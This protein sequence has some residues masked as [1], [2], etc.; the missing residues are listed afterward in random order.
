MMQKRFT[1]TQ[2]LVGRENPRRGAKCSPGHLSAESA[3]SVSQPIHSNFV[4]EEQYMKHRGT[5]LSLS[6][7]AL[8]FALATARAQTYNPVYTYPIGSGAYSGIT[9][10]SLLS[11]GQ[12][13]ALYSTIQN[14][15]DTYGSVYEITTEGQYTMLY[16][17]CAEGSPCA[18]TGGYPTGGVTLG[19]DGNLWGTTK[20][21]GKDGAGTAFKITPAGTLTSLYSFTNGKD[22]SAPTYTLL[23]GQDGNMYGVSEEQYDGQYGSFF[24][25]TTKGKIS[26]YPFDYT[27][28]YT[29]NLPVQGTD[30]N[31]YGTTQSGGD[32]ACVCGVIYKA[33]AA[34][35]IT[36]LHSFSGYVSS[37]Q[38]DGSR[39]IGILVEGADGNFYGTTYQGGEYNAGTVFKITPSG[40]YSLLH[41]F[42][43][44]SPTYD[45][46]LPIAG[47]TLG[48]D[49]DFYGVT[50]NGGTQNGGAIFAITPSGKE[51]VLYSFC[52][53][54]C[55]DGFV[56]TTP[57]V[58]HTDG[59]FY[60]N[61]AGNSNG[62]SVFYSFKTGL[63]PFVKLVTWS[64]KDGA[65]AEILGQ[66]FTGTKTVSFN[67]V[68]AKFDNVSDTYMTATVPA[69]ALTGPVTV[70]TFSSTLRSDRNF[71]VTPQ[72]TSFTPTSGVVGTSVT[73]TG[74]SLTQTTAVT[75]GTK[76]ASFT[77][78]SDTQ[79]TATVP[80]GAKTGKTITV[81]T[82]GG[83]ATSKAKF[84]V[85]PEVTGFS[86]TSGP[87][88]TSVT[89]T[90]N[91]FTGTTQV[92]FGGVAATSYKAK[93]DTTVDA[94]VPM[95]AVTGTIAVT[96]PG[97]TGTSTTK[98]TITK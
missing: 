93:S 59:I 18:S 39:P 72:I 50:S 33:T 26:S 57:L 43:F 70:T 32:A 11:Q 34:G 14:N 82:P 76:T 95:G 65:T 5:A 29:P 4:L 55:L 15:G 81:T 47:L 9:W 73:I 92:T 58:L 2:R 62:G 85:V 6:V 40:T 77:V 41:S 64:G 91:S 17:F 69:G 54:S 42:S 31:F 28:G 23:Q 75:I 53:V 49:G 16:A 20:G 87:V 46:Q 12:D 19:W 52:S 74:I 68:A 63:K 98:F 61:T 78:D 94:L 67:G 90:G 97:G 21:G 10:P 89:I 88:G 44:Q 7:V 71:L 25:L 51:T 96:T 3:G 56:P 83:T 22:D 66:G 86:P 79:M 38:Y 13:G 80:A 84:T 60:G 37:T 45:G 8:L 30:L 1:S 36:V 35:K 48:T 24:K 27:D